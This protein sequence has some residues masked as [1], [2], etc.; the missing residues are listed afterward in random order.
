MNRGSLT[1]VRQKA[2][3]LLLAVAGGGLYLLSFHTSA[4]TSHHLTPHRAIYDVSLYS[5]RNGSSISG[6][7]GSM[8]FEMT[9]A[10]DAWTIQQTMNVK[11][12][13][14]TG[15][16]HVLSNSSATWEAKDGLTFRFSSR[17]FTNDQEKESYRGEAHLNP[18]NS[19]GAAHYVLPKDKTID[20]PAGTMFPM[21]QTL[22]LLRHAEAGDTFYNQT[23]FDGSDQEGLSEANSF[24]GH[25]SDVV[26]AAE[27]GKKDVA[28]D[29]ALLTTPAWPVRIAFFSLKSETGE[30]NYETDEVF[31]ANGV[32]RSFLIDYGDFVLS[33]VLKKL[34]PM[35]KSGC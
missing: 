29:P 9:D 20:L 26:P 30:P 25:R 27:S 28:L 6:A 18:D 19:G 11:F 10:C 34:D 2:L 12:F 32:S 17:Q 15:G 31:Q 22:A 14:N 8:M 35:P 33:A 23:V 1:G 24:V 21:T 5:A 16:E 13:E 3:M 4:T 7:S